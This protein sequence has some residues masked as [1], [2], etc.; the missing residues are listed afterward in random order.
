MQASNLGPEV[1]ALLGLLCAVAVVFALTYQWRTYIK[2]Y[3]TDIKPAKFDF[4]YTWCN[5]GWVSYRH[6]MNIAI[7]PQGLL[8][9]V[10]FPFGF[11]GYKKP[12][13]IPW[14]HLTFEG[15]EFFAYAFKVVPD[16]FAIKCGKKVADKIFEHLPTK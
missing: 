12:L 15:K 14:E 2:K 6:C 3:G 10:G 9:R 16:N 11:L 5:V 8:L 13:L 7:L 4:R 1:A